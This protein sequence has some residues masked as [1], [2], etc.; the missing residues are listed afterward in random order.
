[1]ACQDHVFFLSSLSFVW[2]TVHSRGTNTVLMTDT[3]MNSPTQFQNG[4]DR[5]GAG[6]K[7]KYVPPMPQHV[8]QIQNGIASDTLPAN[9]NSQ[10]ITGTALI[11][12]TLQT[13]STNNPTPAP[14]AQS[15]T[16]LRFSDDCSCANLL[17]RQS[18]FIQTMPTKPRLTQVHRVLLTAAVVFRNDHSTFRD[19][20]IRAVDFEQDRASRSSVPVILVVKPASP[21]HDG[22]S[23]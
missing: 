1:M 10:P 15:G 22:S 3:D 19:A 2:L 8:Q 21:F 16:R 12:P 4:I 11:I 18:Q 20:V 13:T 6:R 17:S 5:H 7:S 14:P 9:D 23:V